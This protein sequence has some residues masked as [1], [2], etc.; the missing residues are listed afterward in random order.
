MSEP[1][2]P[3]QQMKRMSRRS[4]LWAGVAVFGTYGG[5]TWLASRRDD[6]GVAW[7]FRKVLE[8]NEQL[9]R[10]L[11][12]G[13]ALAPT[14]DPARAIEPTVNSLDEEANVEELDID[15]WRLSVA[16]LPGLDE[17]M[18]L[19]MAQL[20][21]LPKIDQTTELNCIEGWTAIVHWTGVRFV[22]LI[23]HITGELMKKA[24]PEDRSG[25]K[26]RPEYVG[27]ESVEGFYYV[28]LDT[29]SALH[30]Q[31]LLAYE[32]NGQP[33]TLEHGAPI[34][35]VIPT[36]Y[37]IKNIKRIGT[38]TFGSAR[39]KDYWAEQGYDWYAGL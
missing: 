34:R 6:D 5:V 30:P 11:Y 1:L 39:P 17:P 12:N 15:E 19:T 10:D 2:E 29:P 23:D 35:L 33:L 27:L 4:F 7:P 9:Q 14:F 16:G 38:I 3:H 31:T 13:M 22:D 25:L 28:G 36:K 26:T 18:Q 37:G 8:A 32:M 24:K 20:K 21:K